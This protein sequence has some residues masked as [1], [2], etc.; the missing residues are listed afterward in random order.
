MAG[1]EV[2]A[3]CIHARLVVCLSW[4]PGARSWRMRC[5]AS[6]GVGLDPAVVVGGGWALAARPRG[7]PGQAGCT[8]GSFVGRDPAAQQ[9]RAPH[10]EANR[11]HP[12]S[13]AELNSSSIYQTLLNLFPPFSPASSSSLRLQRPII[14]PH[15]P[16]SF[17][18]S[19]PQFQSSTHPH[20][21]CTATAWWR[22][23][24]WAWWRCR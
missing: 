3:R 19:S 7:R 24:G 21:R 13:K 12:V 15:M 1:V 16:L 6:R 10:Q 23:K 18:L 17:V 14:Y 4:E 20:L 2:V 8:R 5:W 11:I 22:Q 9:G